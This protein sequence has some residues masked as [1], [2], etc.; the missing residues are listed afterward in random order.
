MPGVAGAVIYRG[1]INPEPS[2]KTDLKERRRCK[3]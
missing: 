1:D 2:D 3:P